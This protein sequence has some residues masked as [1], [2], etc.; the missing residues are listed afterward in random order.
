M[1]QFSLYLT[2]YI[3]K[4][5]F[6]LVLC[7]FLVL[8]SCPYLVYQ[9]S[10]ADTGRSDA[11]ESRPMRPWLACPWMLSHRGVASAWL[12]PYHH[13]HLTF[14]LTS[15]R[16]RYHAKRSGRYRT[17]IKSIL[18]HPHTFFRSFFDCPDDKSLRCHF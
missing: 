16:Y 12:V 5:S 15:S 3:L 10:A 6:Y 2:Y 13:Q 1:L 14:K 4:C 18:S 9:P 11:V 17:D 7:Y 8:L